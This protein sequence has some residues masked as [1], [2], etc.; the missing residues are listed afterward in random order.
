M[1]FGEKKIIDLKS[2]KEKEQSRVSEI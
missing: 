2:R 1:P